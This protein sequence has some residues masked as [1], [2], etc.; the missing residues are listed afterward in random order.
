MRC[1]FINC[2]TQPL[3][4]VVQLSRSYFAALLSCSYSVAKPHGSP[5]GH[6][7]STDSTGAHAFPENEYCCRTIL[8]RNRKFSM[9]ESFLVGEPTNL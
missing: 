2:S 3:Y 5:A 6:V 4:S 8:R 1:T 9:I 7:L